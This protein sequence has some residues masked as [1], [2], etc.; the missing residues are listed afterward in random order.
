MTRVTKTW[1]LN[2]LQ[3]SEIQPSPATVQECTS[4]YKGPKTPPAI[5]PTPKKHHSHPKP[6]RPEGFL[7]WFLVSP[8]FIYHG[9]GK[10]LLHWSSTVHEIL[11]ASRSVCRYFGG[12]TKWYTGIFAKRRT[13]SRIANSKTERTSSCRFTRQC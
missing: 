12:R 11:R 10:T 1:P 5:H 8:R 4:L 6:Q 13:P 2:D 9:A 7:T 3:I